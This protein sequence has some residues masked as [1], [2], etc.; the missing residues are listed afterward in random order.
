MKYEWK[1]GDTLMVLDIPENRDNDTLKSFLGK[2]VVASNDVCEDSEVRNVVDINFPNG[3]RETGFYTRRFAKIS[4]SNVVETKQELHVV[5]KDNCSNVVSLV[6]SYEEAVRI[7]KPGI[8]D[9]TYTIY[10]LIAISRAETKTNLTP[11][12]EEKVSKKKRL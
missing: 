9:G 5:V 3:T 10:K 1:K 8:D 12:A 7:A 6:K 2:C 4:S 11:I